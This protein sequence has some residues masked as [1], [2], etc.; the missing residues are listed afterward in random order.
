MN[1][2]KRLPLVLLALTV[3]T[4]SSRS[5]EPQKEPELNEL[6]QKFVEQLSGVALIGTFTI[7][8]KGE[9]QSLKSERYEI[10]QIS[11][12]RDDYWIFNA[13][14]KYG[15]LDATLPI[16]L[17]VLWA[18]DTPMISMTD[19]AIPGLGT[20]TCRVLFY[21]HRYVGTWQHGKVGGHMFGRI[22]KLKSAD[23]PVQ[24]GNPRE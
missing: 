15:E 11:K 23:E 4:T 20:F 2:L 8:G 6:E 22:E 17:K 19:L 3:L 16:T 12:F 1:S 5:E 9:N 21:E 7:D 10:K 24:N 13:R 18:G 14:V